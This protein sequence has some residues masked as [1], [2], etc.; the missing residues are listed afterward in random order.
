M[1]VEAYQNHDYRADCGDANAN[2]LETHPMF[3]FQAVDG[4]QSRWIGL[5][6]SLF[7]FAHHLG[8]LQRMA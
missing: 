4:C 6:P 5:K 1:I 3:S 2:R 7:E 8:C